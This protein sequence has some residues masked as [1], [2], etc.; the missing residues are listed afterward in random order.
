MSTQVHPIV[1]PNSRY[2]N[3]GGMFSVIDDDNENV[4]TVCAELQTFE[5]ND[6]DELSLASDDDK[7]QEQGQKDYNYLMYLFSQVVCSKESVVMLI[8]VARDIIQLSDFGLFDY[9]FFGNASP[10]E[11]YRRLNVSERTISFLKSVLAGSI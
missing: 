4:S 7:P 10:A 8:P 1:A 6:C 2:Y 5:H 11:T 9:S 3:G